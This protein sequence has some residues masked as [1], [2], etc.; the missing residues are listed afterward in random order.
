MQRGCKLLAFGFWLLALEETKTKTFTDYRLPFTDHAAPL[1]NRYS[2]RKASEAL[3]QAMPRLHLCFL[4]KNIT[5]AVLL[6]EYAA[7]L[8]WQ[9]CIGYER[10]KIY[11]RQRCARQ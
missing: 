2:N 7:S 5:F 3:Y 6:V 1:H 4:R 9:V 10:R 11:Q 8:K